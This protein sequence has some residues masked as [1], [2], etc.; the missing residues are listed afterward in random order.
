[1]LVAMPTAMPGRSVDQQIRN[2]RRQH[3]GLDSPF[4]EIG[5]EIDGLFV[6]IFQQRGVDAREP[7]FGVPIGRRRIAVHRAEISLP[8]HQRIAQREIL[9]HA[10]QRVI[11]RRVAV[12]MV[13]AQHFADDARAF[14]IGAVERQPHLRHRIENAAMHRLQ[15]VADV[16]Q[17]APDDHAHGVI[18]IRPPHLVFDV[19]G[20][21]VLLAVAAER[22]LGAVAGRSLRVRWDLGGLP[23]S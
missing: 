22:H 6:E 10:N 14:A 23:T 18:E 5:P 4:I 12:R 2:A 15:A 19:D 8:I 1:M 21:Q 16:G 9:R 3:F 13:I 17:R 7:R 11:H 20:D